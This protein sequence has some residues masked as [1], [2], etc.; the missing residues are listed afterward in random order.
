MWNL[1]QSSNYNMSTLYRQNN[2]GE[3]IRFA[4]HLCQELTNFKFMDYFGRTYKCIFP[5]YLDLYN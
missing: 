2:N 4:F 1:I 5:M 3:N